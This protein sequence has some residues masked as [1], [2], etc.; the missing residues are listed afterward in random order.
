MRCQAKL[1]D[2]NSVRRTF[3]VLRESLRRE[4]E[5]GKVEPLPETTALVEQLTA[6]TPLRIG[7]LNAVEDDWRFRVSS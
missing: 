4:L 1:G 6:S 5:D 7:D 3:K 2:G